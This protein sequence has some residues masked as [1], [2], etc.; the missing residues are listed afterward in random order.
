MSIA[1]VHLLGSEN[2][3]KI[4][5]YTDVASDKKLKQATFNKRISL[6]H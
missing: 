5:L 2:G 6:S 1:V 4:L 3:H